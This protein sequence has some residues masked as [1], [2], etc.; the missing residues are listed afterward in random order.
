MTA[1]E[2]IEH[3]KTTFAKCVDVMTKK[4]ADYSSSDAN[5]FR[6]FELVEHLKIADKK[7]GLLVRLADKLS[8]VAN[9]LTKDAA[10]VEESLQDT[11]ED[12]INY[13]VILHAMLESD[14]RSRPAQAM[15]GVAI[16]VR[17]PYGGICQANGKPLNE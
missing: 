8:R 5:A 13:L 17:K 11:V 12:A 10:V 4:N 3:A 6:N 16:N 1:V 14:K 2:L 15:K 7:S 9:L